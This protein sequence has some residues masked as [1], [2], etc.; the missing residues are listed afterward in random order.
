M[1][2]TAILGLATTTANTIRCHRFAGP[3]L[4]LVY[5]PLQS[6]PQELSLYEMFCANF[7]ER[8]DDGE[9]SVYDNK[10]VPFRYPARAAV[11]RLLH[12]GIIPEVI[13]IDCDLDYRPL[14]ALLNYLMDTLFL[15]Y[16]CHIAG[17][18]WAVSEVSHAKPAIKTFTPFPLPPS[19][20]LFVFS[21]LIPSPK[22]GRSQEERRKKGKLGVPFEHLSR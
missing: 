17:G 22:I 1:N 12:V 3:C 4:A 13:Y 5:C 16:P 2:A 18:G 6:I 21:P 11:E 14:K 20:V 15:R 7:F 9:G 8:Q 19:F 10:V